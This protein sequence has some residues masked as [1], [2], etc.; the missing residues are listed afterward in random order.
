MTDPF[1]TLGINSNAS[2]DEIKSAYRKLAKKYHPDVNGGSAEAEAKMKEIN[3]AYSEALK[4]KRSGG[5]YNPNANRGYSSSQG[6]GSQ[7]YSSQQGGYEDPFGFGFGFGDF[8]F[9]GQQRRTY[10]S[11][12]PELRAAR[13]YI[14]TGHYQEA[15][16]LLQRTNDR[17]AE[18]FYLSAR[19]NIGLGNRTAALTYARQ[20]VQMDPDSYEYAQLLSR[21]EGNS[22]NYRRSSST[23]GGIPLTQ[24]SSPCAWICMLNM[25]CNCCCPGRYFFC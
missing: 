16:N 22:A 10:E 5:T 11:S 18:W 9:G 3:E 2:E 1:S 6:Y 8:G 23:H 12:S 17:S 13:N 4:I 15:L 24:C 25:L 20:A 14:N 7:G 21:L 19:A